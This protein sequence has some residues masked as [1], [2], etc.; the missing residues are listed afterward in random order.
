MA[1]LPFDQTVV[2]SEA[3]KDKMPEGPLQVG[4]INREFQEKSALKTA[5]DLN[6][7]ASIAQ[8]ADTEIGKE[9]TADPESPELAKASDIYNE[10]AKPMN[11]FIA[12]QI[13]E[14]TKSVKEESGE[15][16]RRS[17]NNQ[18]YILS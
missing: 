8:A 1:N 18:S 17:P 3:G 7:A 9:K 6:E 11:N 2:I 13:D 14:K 16:N 12:A 10:I 15:N 5:K 4:K